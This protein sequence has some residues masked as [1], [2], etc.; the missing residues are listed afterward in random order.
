MRTGRHPLIVIDAW[1]PLAFLGGTTARTVAGHST[2]GSR[3]VGNIPGCTAIHCMC[4]ARKCITLHPD[5]V[6][7][8]ARNGLHKPCVLGWRVSTTVFGRYRA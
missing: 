4:C 2:H 1:V 8:N 3:K 6:H 5:A 7:R